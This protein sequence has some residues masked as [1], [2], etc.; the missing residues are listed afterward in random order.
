MKNIFL[1]K[2]QFLWSQKKKIVSCFDALFPSVFRFFFF[3]IQKKWCVNLINFCGKC[4]DRDEYIPVG[5]W[6]ANFVVIVFYTLKINMLNSWLP[7][8]KMLTWDMD[9][10]KKI[11]SGRKKL[12]KFLLHL[13]ASIK[14]KTTRIKIGFIDYIDY[15]DIYMLISYTWSHINFIIKKKKKCRC[16]VESRHQGILIYFLNKKIRRLSLACLYSVGEDV[17]FDLLFFEV[18]PSATLT[19][20]IAIVIRS[21]ERSSMCVY[22]RNGLK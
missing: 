14:R 6:I 12:R 11:F 13:L 19:F 5:V 17:F 3:F 22:F 7:S 9:L 16:R 2:R 4:C 15:H 1:S 20:I 8:T 18:N 10:K 21:M